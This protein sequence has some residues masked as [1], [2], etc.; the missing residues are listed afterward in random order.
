VATESGQEGLHSNYLSF[1]AVLAQSVATISPSPAAAIAPALIFAIAGNGTWLSILIAGAGSILVAM[2]IVWLSRQLASSGSLYTYAGASFGPFGGVITGWAMLLAYGIGAAAAVV[3]IEI[4][5]DQVFNLPE[6]GIVHS[7]IYLV[8]LVFSFLFA[9]RDIK[10]SAVFSLVVEAIS[11]TLV[12]LLGVI[13]LVHY[14]PHLDLQ[15]LGLRGTNPTMIREGLVLAAGMFAGFEGCAVLGSEAKNPHRTIPLAVLSS[16]IAVGIYFIFMAYAETAG[17]EGSGRSF[18]QS[19]APLDTLSQILGVSY[20]GRLISLGLTIGIFAAVI[21]MLNAGSRIIYTMARDGILP[22]QLGRVHPKYQTPYIALSILA[23]PTWVIPFAFVV[24]RTPVETVNGY[25]GTIVGY[26]FLVAYFLISI[27][28]L[29]FLHKRNELRPHHIVIGLLGAGMMVFVLAG[30]LYPPPPA[31]Y[32]IFP[33]LIAAYFVAGVVFYLILRAR[34]PHL[35][36]RI[37]DTVTIASQG[38]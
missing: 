13:A 19:E 6:T 21:G 7:V 16:V 26:G 18:A 14:G 12:T 15:Q 27:A 24:S 30:Q 35:V 31:P 38:S 36:D 17:F 33:Y 9:Y 37:G 20:L 25:L 1:P 8:V 11:I 22:A 10:L 29:V 34:A 28:A 5:A 4:Y 23:V 32:V 3:I 2:T